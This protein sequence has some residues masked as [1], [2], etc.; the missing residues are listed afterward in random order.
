M[1]VKLRNQTG[2]PVS[3]TLNSRAAL[4]LPPRGTS[5]VLMEAEV[6]GNPKVQKLGARGVI[7]V[8]EAEEAGAED[9]GSAEAR[10]GRPD[11]PHERPPVRAPRDRRAGP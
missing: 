7:T 6:S 3:I 2:R 10:R 8:M 5:P 9:R 1:P 11:A 4:H